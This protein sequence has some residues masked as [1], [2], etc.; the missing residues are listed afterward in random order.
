MSMLH[1]NYVNIGLSSGENSIMFDSMHAAKQIKASTFV[2]NRFHPYTSDVINRQKHPYESYF[3]SGYYSGI[4]RNGPVPTGGS[5]VSSSGH[6]F[7]PGTYLPKSHQYH[8][9]NQHTNFQWALTPTCIQNLCDLNADTGTSLQLSSSVPG[10]DRSHPFYSR[11]RSEPAEGM[12]RTRD[13]YRVVYSD[14]QRRGLEKEYNSNKFITIEMRA[15]ISEELGLSARQVPIFLYD[16][17]IEIIYIYEISKMFTPA[18]V[19]FGV[20]L[21]GFSITF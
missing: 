4:G 1:E 5:N 3:A 13:K 10:K 16:C 14:K 20:Q 15:R 8:N 6:N 12:T 2:H 11:K 19:K 18:V 17:S 7:I 9:E 21:Y